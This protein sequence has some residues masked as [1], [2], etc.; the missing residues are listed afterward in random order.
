M[1]EPRIPVRMNHLCC[2]V[3]NQILRSPVTVPCGHNF[4]LQ[5][6]QDRWDGDERSD[7]FCSCPECGH[8]FLSRPQ[9]ISNTTLAEL[10]RDTEQ[11]DAESWR[12]TH[13]C[14]SA[15][16]LRRGQSW[17]ET[18][19]PLCGRHGS[20]LDVYC[21]TDEQII[22]AV[23]ASSEH[24]GHTIGSVMGESRRKQVRKQKHKE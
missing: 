16:A 19:N 15:Q 18:G 22:C 11:R 4:C 23:C 6:I 21:C 12:Q 7:S 8:E 1:A 3:C 17:R 2:P 14:V 24:M 10:V 20:F 9:L 13:P 5:C